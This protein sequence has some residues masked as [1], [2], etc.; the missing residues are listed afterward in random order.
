LQLF[1]YFYNNRLNVHKKV[2]TLS[3]ADKVAVLLREIGT[4]EAQYTQGN[5]DQAT[6]N[7]VVKKLRDYNNVTGAGIINV[8][9]LINSWDQIRFEKDAFIKSWKDKGNKEVT[10]AKKIVAGEALTY[11]ET[12]YFKEKMLDNI[13]EM[14]TFEGKINTAIIGEDENGKVLQI[15]LEHEKVGNFIDIKGA[16]FNTTD[17][18]ASDNNMRIMVSMNSHSVFAT[19]KTETENISKDHP[20]LGTK[21]VVYE[22]FTVISKEVNK[23]EYDEGIRDSIELYSYHEVKIGD[24]NTIQTDKMAPALLMNLLNEKTDSPLTVDELSTQMEA[25]KQDLM[26]QRDNYEVM[27]SEVA[28]DYQGIDY[29]TQKEKVQKD[30]I[31]DLT[32]QINAINNA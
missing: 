13:I 19:T 9:A 17:L 22:E 31:S 18:D 24:T 12:Q 32:S 14:G 3:D 16:V 25:L 29:N 5:V 20:E 26:Y 6:L 1:S 15:S 2:K 27:F 30:I 11:E 21:T 10:I 23:V 4:F 28:N 7:N 8:D